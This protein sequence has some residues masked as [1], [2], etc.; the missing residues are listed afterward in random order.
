[1]VNQ[2]S[3]FPENLHLDSRGPQRV[4][5]AFVRFS[6]KDSFWVPA[7]PG[8]KMLAQQRGMGAKASSSVSSAD[9]ARG[10]DSPALETQPRSQARRMR[11]LV[12]Y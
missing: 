9:G 7:C 10:S 5:E 6:I 1:M 8:L 12:P 3:I 2:E 4:R 11:S